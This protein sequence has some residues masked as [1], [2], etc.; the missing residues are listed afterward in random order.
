M[1]ARSKKIELIY[2][3]PIQCRRKPY[4]DKLSPFSAVPQPIVRSKP[5]WSRQFSYIESQRPQTNVGE[6]SPLVQR[7][8]SPLDVAFENTPTYIPEY[9]VEHLQQNDPDYLFV[10]RNMFTAFALVGATLLNTMDF[11]A[12]LRLWFSIA[13]MVVAVMLAVAGLAS[14]WQKYSNQPTAYYERKPWH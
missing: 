9:K 3:P 5:K 8:R 6:I 1:R 13:L 7:Y 2:A 10:S 14:L 11:S 4:V 12:T